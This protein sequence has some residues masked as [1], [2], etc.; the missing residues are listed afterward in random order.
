MNKI[1]LMPINE[2]EDTIIDIIKINEGTKSTV[3]ATK[4]YIELTNLIEQ[5]DCKIDNNTYSIREGMW[6]QLV[7]LGYIPF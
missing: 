4:R 6:K 2:F 1:E 3:D 7:R 5:E